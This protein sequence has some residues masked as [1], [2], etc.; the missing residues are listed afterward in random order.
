MVNMRN[1]GIPIHGFGWQ[2]HVTASQVL[3]PDFPLEDRMNRVAQL[4]F[5][6]YVTELDIV[7]DERRV[8]GSLP[9]PKS[10]YLL[11]DLARQGAAYQKITEILIRAER[12]VAMQFWGVS[13]KQSWLGAERK[14]LI[15]DKVFR[16]KP[17]YEAV[18]D[19][20]LRAT[21]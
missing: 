9:A 10:V 14:P 5:D 20:L 3:D 2:L 21:P 13:D 8:D 19:V 15:F 17:A 18:A 7:M 16:K 12:C 1:R 6:N 11:K 4:G